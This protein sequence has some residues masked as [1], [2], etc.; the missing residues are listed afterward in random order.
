M[1]SLE[2]IPGSVCAPAGFRAGTSAAGLKESGDPDIA[3]IVSD[4]PATAAGVFTTNRVVAAPVVL[5]KERA[6][7][8]QA[9]GIV[10]NAGN[11]NACTGNQGLADAHRMAAVAAEALGVGPEEVLVAST[12][13]IGHRL[14]MERVEAGIRE[15][16]GRLEADGAAAA[17]AILTTDTRPKEIAVAVTVGGQRIRVGGIAKGSGMIGPRM[18]TLLAFVTTDAAIWPEVLQAS[19]RSAV[20]RTFNCLTVDG[21]MSTNDCLLVLANGA[22][23]VNAAPGSP[24]HTAFCEALLHVCTHLTRELARD[25]EGATK[26]MQV[27]VTG[28]RSALQARQVAM[29]IANSPLVKTAIFGNDPNWGRILAAAGRAGVPL[30]PVRLQL[31]LGGIPL[32][33]GGE[34]LPYDA[35]EAR[36]ALAAEEVCVVLDLG[37]GR[38]AATVWSCD[39][40]YDYVRINAEY[41]T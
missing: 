17:R 7:R 36:K 4:R 13:V 2:A 8:G 1:G 16:A 15:A 29:T 25:G 33:R 11:A 6:A 9:R 12:G 22:A 24:V 37:Q 34:P 3:L 35:G 19:L 32:V 14:P 38:F 5:A 30:D 28:A 21:D 26:R 23:G 18:A 20:E 41:H 39:F 27:E 40:S 10:V 31:T